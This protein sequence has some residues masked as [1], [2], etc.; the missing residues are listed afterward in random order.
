VGVSTDAMG[1]EL[2][3][4][5][6]A[7]LRSSLRG[8]QTH[9]HGSNANC[10]TPSPVPGAETGG[11]AAGDVHA[12]GASVVACSGGAGGGY[13]HSGGEAMGGY[14]QATL[15]ACGRLLSEFQV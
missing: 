2:A 6:H 9:A 7:S 3:E 10:N 12:G 14:W 15:D 13:W 11:A 1:Q 5:R 8:A 4:S